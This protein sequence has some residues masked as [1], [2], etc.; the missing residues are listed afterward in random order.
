[1]RT[2]G[3][4]IFLGAF[5][6]FLVQ[7]LVGKALL[8]WFGG[9]PAVWAT[10][11][12]FFQSALLAGYALAH[13]LGSAL[14]DRGQRRVFLA[15]IGVA[16]A[17][18]VG[19]GATWSSPI[20]PGAAWQPDPNGSPLVQI[21]VL[22]AAST[23]LPYLALAA[24]GPLLQGWF[25]RAVP[26]ASPYPLYALSNAGSLAALVAFP[27][28]LEPYAG[29][30]TQGWMWCGGFVVFALA[31][32]LASRA[33][34]ARP[35]PNAAT[36]TD[37]EGPRPDLS[38][39]VA[40]FALSLASSMLLCATTNHLG[41]EIVV[42]PFLWIA[43]LAIYLVT[44]IVAF[45]P[46]G[47]TRTAWMAQALFAGIAL[48]AMFSSG[49]QSHLG[50]QLGVFLYA[51][52]VGCMAC[53]GELAR[54]RP[55]ARWLT[56]YY[57]TSAAGGAAGGMLVG[58]AAPTFLVATHEYHAAILVAVWS[59][60]GAVVADGS[61][62]LRRAS[63][64]HIAPLAG[65]ALVACLGWELREEVGPAVCRAWG[66]P[67]WSY[68][69]A[70][71]VLALACAIATL[72]RRL[73]ER[74]PS[75]HPIWTWVLVL[76]A[77]IPLHHALIEHAV[78]HLR[79]ARHQSRSFYGVLRVVDAQNKDMHRKQTRTLVHGTVVH[80]LQLLEPELRRVP[81]TY[82][83]PGTG[84]GRAIE[85]HPRRAAGAPMRIGA[86][87]LGIGTIA[88]LAQAGDVVRFYEINRAVIE[89]ALPGS[90]YFSFLYDSPA[91]IEVALG[92]ARL[93]LAQEDSQAYDVIVV[94]A[95]T[96]GAIPTHL[97]SIEA[98][99]LYLRHLR[100]E[101]G[102]LAF[103][104][105][106]NYLD[107]AP[108]LHGAADRLGLARIETRISRSMPEPWQFTSDWMLLSRDPAVLAHPALVALRHE[109]D[110]PRAPIV[111][112]D[113]RSNLLEVLVWGN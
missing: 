39:A 82:Y 68:T 41:E 98:I 79:G 6:L 29:S 63:E 109:G 4:A 12:V 8:P 108:V 91:Q 97:L 77:M 15:L 85:H 47:Y 46:S 103:H 110:A 87:G 40:W 33:A 51:L 65:I 13:G 76:V 18:Q 81:T 86:V 9:T 74:L 11:M 20:T 70:C 61:S 24:T 90:P 3:V 43:P 10:C 57:L 99:A 37:A 67:P 54:L 31:V 101:P 93:Q 104:I 89:L 64:T 105:S 38:R 49:H 32:G 102:V 92:D 1:M 71:A 28:L 69:V 60:L 73:R 96:G 100:D 45:T 26:D 88:A 94:D 75:G 50:L 83:G 66:T 17:A 95:F 23:G 52:L 27:V 44:L 112:T 107:L 106:N 19:L 42:A 72:V 48:V 30:S 58:L 16:L 2:F 35:S 36:A 62:G 25:A 22:L 59:V 80:G 53:H 84:L 14:D 113:D 55:P 56:R 111:W 78:R 7:P 34:A 21:L 5:L